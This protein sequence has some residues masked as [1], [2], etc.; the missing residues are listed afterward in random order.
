MQEWIIAMLVIS[1]MLILRDMAKTFFK[2][3]EPGEEAAAAIMECHP[4]REKIERYAE[5]FQKLADTFYGMPYRKEYFS[6]GQVGHILENVNESICSKCY[7][8][9]ICW[10]EYAEQMYRYA[11]AMIRSMEEGDEAEYMRLRE[12]W[13]GICNKYS[14]YTEL[15]KEEFQKEKQNLFWSNRMIENR[16]AVAQQLSEM[17][18][19]MRTVTEDIYDI[20]KGSEV[21]Q[22][23]LEKQLKKKRVQVK[24]VWVM[25]HVE[26]R[27]QI[28][29]NMRAKRGTCISML[30]ISQVLS[31]ICNCAMTTASGSRSIVNG[32]YH[33]VHFIEEVSYQVMYGVSKITREEEKVSGDNFICRQEEDGKFVMCLS[34]GM[35]SGREA[36]EE[37]ERV[38]ELLEQ[39]LDSGFGQETVA[40][41]INSAMVQNGREEMFSTLDLCAIDLYTGICSFLKAGAAAT[42]VKRD[43]WV[44]VISSE[45][46][47]A[48]LVQQLDFDVVSKKLYHGDFVIMMSDGVLDAL[49][50]EREE[51][52][53]KEIIL[54]IQER[55]PKEIS[56]GI[57]ERVL[58][59]SDYRAKDDMTVLMAAVWKK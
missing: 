6:Q 41:M 32:E 22:N 8:R 54:E 2:G 35:G 44:E 23:E 52:T 29:I 5:A 51:E 36:C 46:L 21:L 19:I 40:R 12:E 53:M 24:E 57:L 49:P 15:L 16:L 20:A 3:R 17:A 39:F 1:V 31:E 50:M 34:D 27:R 48:G 37:S 13:L 11:Q 58:G 33:I 26:G 42:F 9:E 45:S 25:D 10:H 30:E 43:H 18:K 56:R 14:Q 7:Q 4:Q 28:F 59:Y 47:A 38:V 55:T